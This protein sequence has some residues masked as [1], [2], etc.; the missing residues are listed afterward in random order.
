M[1]ALIQL[2][3]VTYHLAGRTLLSEV[4]VTI[5]DGDVIGIVGPNGAGS[6]PY[7]SY[8]TEKSSRKKVK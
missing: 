6:Q 1:E 3:N 4:N 8:C 2:T 7:F 5:Y